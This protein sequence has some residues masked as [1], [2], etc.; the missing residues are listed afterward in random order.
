MASDVE[1]IEN[2]L[3]LKNRRGAM[4]NLGYI[5]LLSYAIL[6]VILMFVGFIIIVPVIWVKE[7]LI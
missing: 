6:R 7:K 3:D 1:W 5:G 4:R 2:K